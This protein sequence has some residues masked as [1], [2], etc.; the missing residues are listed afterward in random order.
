[1]DSASAWSHLCYLNSGEAA[2]YRAEMEYH[3][4]KARTIPIQ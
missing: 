2:K 4:G 3:I 1:M